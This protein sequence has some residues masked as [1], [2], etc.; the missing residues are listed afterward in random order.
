M[1]WDFCKSCDVH[2]ILKNGD[3]VDSSKIVLNAVLLQNEN[4][5]LPVDCPLCRHEGNLKEYGFVLES[6]K[7][8]KIWMK[9]LWR[10]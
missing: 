9:N 10:P 5:H 6:C 2:T 8:L 4:I 3:F 7:L 1:M